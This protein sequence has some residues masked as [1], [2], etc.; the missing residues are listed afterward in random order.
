MSDDCDTRTPPPEG[1]CYDTS[2]IGNSNAG[3]TYGTALA[4]AE[5]ENL[6]AYLLTL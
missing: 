2:L 3:H 4:P 6:L 1:F 5:K